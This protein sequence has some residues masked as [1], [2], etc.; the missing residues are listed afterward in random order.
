[1]YIGGKPFPL[2]S[3]I[4]SGKNEQEGSN[5]SLAV[6]KRSEQHKRESPK[7]HCIRD[8]DSNGRIQPMSLC[9]RRSKGKTREEAEA[10]YV[11]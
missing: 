3:I 2:R 8:N 6:D 7:A 11:R 1:M 4:S 9:F 5:E 10:R